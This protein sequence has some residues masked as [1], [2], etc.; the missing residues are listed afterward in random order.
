[1]TAAA[2][3]G[4][5]WDFL[6]ALTGAPAEYCATAAVEELFVALEELGAAEAWLMLLLLAAAAALGELELDTRT[7]ED[8]AM[9]ELE[10]EDG[11]TVELKAGA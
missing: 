9:V 4:A 3:N 10:E 6:A 1:M 5:R 11:A 2:T 7:E 8:G